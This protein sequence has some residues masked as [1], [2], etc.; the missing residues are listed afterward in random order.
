MEKC[1][2]KKG[3]G[4]PKIQAKVNNYFLAIQGT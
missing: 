3:H 2:K 4:F 1:V